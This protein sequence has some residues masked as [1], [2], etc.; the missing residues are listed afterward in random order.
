MSGGSDRVRAPPGLEKPQETPSGSHRNGNHTRRSSEQLT[1]LRGSIEKLNAKSETFSAL[2]KADALHAQ[3]VK[4]LSDQMTRL[5]GRLR[6]LEE[7]AHATPL[8]G[9]RI[10]R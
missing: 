4:H 1:A 3:E 6:H 9:A 10:P 7:L 8:P 2:E 5:E